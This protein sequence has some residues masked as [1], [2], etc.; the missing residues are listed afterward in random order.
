MWSAME[1]LCERRAERR[2]RLQDHPHPA[3][4]PGAGPDHRYVVINQGMARLSERVP[5]RRYEP[6]GPQHHWDTALGVP[7]HH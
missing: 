1:K 4:S 6:R 2:L 7:E 3:S 5:R